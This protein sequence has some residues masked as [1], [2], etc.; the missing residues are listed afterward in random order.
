MYTKEFIKSVAPFGAS[1]YIVKTKF[2]I[3]FRNIGQGTYDHC[4]YWFEYK[5]TDQWYTKRQNIPYS[6]SELKEI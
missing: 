1:H 4:L 3:F 5:D 6:F 2:V